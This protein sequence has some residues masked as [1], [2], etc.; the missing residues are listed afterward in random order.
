MTNRGPFIQSAL[1]QWQEVQE[2][3]EGILRYDRYVVP[4]LAPLTLAPMVSAWAVNAA[5]ERAG[6]WWEGYALAFARFAVLSTVAGLA[7]VGLAGGMMVAAWSAGFGRRHVLRW[8]GVG[9]SA[10]IGLSYQLV[11]ADY[12]AS[13]QEGVSRVVQ[14]G[15]VLVEAIDRFH[16]QYGRIPA[17]LSE[18]DGRFVSDSGIGMAGYADFAYTA[19]FGRETYTLNLPLYTWPQ[20]AVEITFR[21]AP[22]PN[23]T[24]PTIRYGEW[25]IEDDGPK[26]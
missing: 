9:L 6:A 14:K 2:A 8:F 12:G 1:S 18:L 21:S 26:R 17:R 16:T 20:K 10:I 5:F 7:M 23:A 15:E 4:F 19:S 24:D 3:F 25:S 22:P 11:M 13:R